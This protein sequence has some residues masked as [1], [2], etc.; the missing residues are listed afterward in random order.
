[1]CQGLRL[2]SVKWS[3]VTDLGLLTSCMEGQSNMVDLVRVLPALRRVPRLA[4]AEPPFCPSGT[5]RREREM[6]VPVSRSIS[7]CNRGKV[8]LV[9]FSTGSRSTA[10]ATA[11]VR[12][13]FSPEGSR[14][15]SGAQWDYRKI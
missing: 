10:L 13:P 12:S 7:A 4:P 8:Q 5:L 14:S 6:R 3:D 2:I 11:R 1:M 9:R 15:Q